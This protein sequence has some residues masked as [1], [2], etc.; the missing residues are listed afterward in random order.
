[1]LLHSPDEQVQLGSSFNR[2]H[3]AGDHINPHSRQMGKMEK[4]SKA[5]LLGKHY[6]G[7]KFLPHNS[8]TFELNEGL[9]SPLRAALVCFLP[10][11]P[12]DLYSCK[13]STLLRV[14]THSSL[15]QSFLSGA[16]CYC[17]PAGKSS[18]KGGGRKALTKLCKER[19]RCKAPVL[20]VG[21]LR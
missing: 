19:W 1:M 18:R 5:T 8:L 21:G 11:F 16:W 3:A 4:E 20:S 10:H 12:S 2:I 6:E 7:V 14:K 15:R 9:L 17:H 13:R